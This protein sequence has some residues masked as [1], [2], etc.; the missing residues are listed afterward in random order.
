MYGIFLGGSLSLWN[1]WDGPITRNQDAQDAVT[2]DVPVTDSVDAI[3]SN[4][5]FDQLQDR[6]S[7]DR[8]SS[9]FWGRFIYG[10]CSFY[11]RECYGIKH[12]RPYRLLPRILATMR[13]TL[14]GQ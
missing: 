3:V 12:Y 10:T 6:F 1:Y 5:I 9:K 14:R 2:V 4:A 7:C 8:P 11:H 13:P